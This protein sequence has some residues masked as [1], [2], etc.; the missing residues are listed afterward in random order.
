MI[1]DA[2]H[3]GYGESLRQSGLAGFAITSACGLS[4]ITVDKTFEDVDRGPT[5]QGMFTYTLCQVLTQAPAALTYDELIEAVSARYRAEGRLESNPWASG[6]DAARLVLGLEQ[7]S[8]RPAVMVIPRLQGGLMVN[9]GSLNGLRPGMILAVRSFEASEATE[10]MGF[11]RVAQTLEDSARA[12]RC[13]DRGQAVTRCAIPAGKP[14]R[15]GVLRRCFL[16]HR[17]DSE[18]WEIAMLLKNCGPGSMS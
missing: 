4:E 10:P 17:C 7:W 6:P 9:A 13:A 14:L 18:S 3:G 1:Y 5:A 2:C 15:A 8:G 12:Q 16:S 11:V